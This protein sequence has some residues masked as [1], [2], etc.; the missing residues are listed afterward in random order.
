MVDKPQGSKSTLRKLRQ[1]GSKNQI[2][3][4]LLLGVVF[5]K[6]SALRR[7]KLSRKKGTYIATSVA[8][9]NPDVKNFT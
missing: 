5:I 3:F 2:D 8:K 4:N 6:Y 9:R 7:G 1:T